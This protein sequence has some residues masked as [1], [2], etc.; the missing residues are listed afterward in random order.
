MCPCSRTM[1]CMVPVRRHHHGVILPMGMRMPA[2]LNPAARPHEVAAPATSAACRAGPHRPAHP[3]H[4]RF[5]N[6][7]QLCRSLWGPSLIV[8]QCA[9]SDGERGFRQAINKFVETGAVGHGSI[10]CSRHPRTNRR[11]ENSSP[12]NAMEV[13]WGLRKS[14]AGR[15][16]GIHN[17]FYKRKSQEKNIPHRRNFSCFPAPWTEQDVFGPATPFARLLGMGRGGWRFLS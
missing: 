10:V 6:G 13:R 1:A 17:A 3:I 12:T 11:T 4:I 2:V 7:I 14:A 9:L 5:P 8:L 15:S 16:G